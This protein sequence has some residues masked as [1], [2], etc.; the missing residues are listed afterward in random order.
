MSAPLLEVKDLRVHFH[1]EDGI[2]R[3]V[4]GVSYSVQRGRAKLVCCLAALTSCGSDR[5]LAIVACRNASS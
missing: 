2:V 3:A 1:T 5:S 4:D